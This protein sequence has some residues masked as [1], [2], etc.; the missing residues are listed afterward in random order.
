[1]E[2]VMGF[3]KSL[4]PVMRKPHGAGPAKVTLSGMAA[5]GS[6]RRGCCGVGKFGVPKG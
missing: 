5:G 2:T 1:M 6:A 4:P 3:P